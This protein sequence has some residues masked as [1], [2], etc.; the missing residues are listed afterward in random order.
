M[1]KPEDVTNS[2]YAPWLEGLI[3]MIMQDK[4]V[5]IG[6]CAIEEDGT[7]TTGYYGEICAEDK[8]VM[9]YHHF[10]DSMMDLV[11]ANAREIIDSAEEEED[12]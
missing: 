8:A 1:A 11:C 6:V 2:P 4:P 12:E 9:A 3:H 7:A 5:R 10:A